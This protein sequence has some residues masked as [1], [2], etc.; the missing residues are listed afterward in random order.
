MSLWKSP[1]LQAYARGFIRHAVRLMK[2]PLSR[3]HETR[4]TIALSIVGSSHSVA[5]PH[6]RVNCHRRSPSSLPAKPALLSFTKLLL[7]VIDHSTLY[8]CLNSR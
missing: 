4:L 6:S 5:V 3:A 8:R 1:R 7:L 2:L